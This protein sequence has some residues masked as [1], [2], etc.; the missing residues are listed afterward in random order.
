MFN[1]KMFCKFKFPEVLSM[2]RAAP[3]EHQSMGLER[4]HRSGS[5]GSSSR[6][7]SEPRLGGMRYSEKAVIRP[8][9]EISR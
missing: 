1:E 7:H 3:L 5:P 8:E 9:L 2:I 4:Y 6:L